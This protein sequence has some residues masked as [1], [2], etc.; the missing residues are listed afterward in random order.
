MSAIIEVGSC[1]REVKSLV[2][3]LVN[4]RL[5]WFNEPTESGPSECESDLD[6]RL[7][8]R[9]AVEQHRTNVLSKIM[10]LLK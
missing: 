10:I 4:L 7:S 6:K 5:Y 3:K 2:D 9:G 1:E 8:I